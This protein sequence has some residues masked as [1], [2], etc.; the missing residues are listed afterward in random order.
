MTTS[1]DTRLAA[2]RKLD[3]LAEVVY[4]A[5]QAWYENLESA[6]A[7]A[8][9]RAAKAAF[10]DYERRC[11]DAGAAETCDRCGGAGGWEGWPGFTCFKCGGHGVMPLRKRKFQAQPSTR[12][13]RDAEQQAVMSERERAYRT[14]LAELGEIG[15]ALEAARQ[16]VDF[17]EEREPSRETFFR[18]EL[19]RKLY[20]FGSLSDA[21]VDAVRR[22]IERQAERAAEIASAGPFPEGR[23]LIEGEVVSDKWTEDRGYGSQHKMLV[24]LADGN[25]IYG[26]VP[27]TIE[28][29][30]VNSWDQ[31]TGDVIPGMELRGAHVRFTATA[32]RSRDDEHFGFYSRPTKAEILTTGAPA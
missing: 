3:E 27:R 26:T 18:A 4:A 8:D 16:E 29:A 25:K 9:Y 22:G 21:Q 10:R 23:V 17:N 6:E 1:T 11:L 19:A 13:K 15:E 12:A 20:R 5:D 31:Q 7:R 24:K 30:C 2:S 32:E 28:D 14:A